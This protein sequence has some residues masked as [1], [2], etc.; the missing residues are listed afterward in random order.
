MIFLFAHI[1]T[2]EN[3]RKSSLKIIFFDSF[4]T[5]LSYIFSIIYIIYT[6]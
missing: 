2:C 4:F 5:F 6:Q 1:G 3:D